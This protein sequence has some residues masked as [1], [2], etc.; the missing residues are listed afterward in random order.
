[1]PKTLEKNNLELTEEIFSSCLPEYL[2]KKSRLYFTPIRIAQIAT[3]WL[4]EDGKKKVLDIGAGVGKF[5][6]AGAIHSNSY[7]YG[8][9]YRPSLAA[10][11]NELI[12]HFKI[13]NAI[14]I[15]SDV[16]NID[17]KDFD[18]FYMYNPFYENLIS[19]VR[20]N[21]EVELSGALYKY[22]FSYTEQQLDKTKS[23]TRLVT[24]HGNNFE[25]PDS[26]I[27]AKETEG[28][29]LKLWIKK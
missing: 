1:M 20:L 26:F 15:N 28:G 24:F 18:A 6:I 4:T 9:E 27:K 13:K 8:I 21:N 19:S 2:Q 14:I 7:F 25:I 22:Y 23:G 29:S 11:A 3:Q 12:G 16:T 17:F 10:L 5:C